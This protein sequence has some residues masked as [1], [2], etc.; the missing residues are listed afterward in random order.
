MQQTKLRNVAI[1]A[2]VDHDDDPM[3]QL[4]GTGEDEAGLGH[5]ALSGVHQQD[6]A[7]DHL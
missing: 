6:D 2:H 1:I 5:G 7:V 3:S 4:Q